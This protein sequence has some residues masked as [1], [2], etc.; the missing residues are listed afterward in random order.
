MAAYV[1]LGAETGLP[2]DVAE[3]RRSGIR[4]HQGAEIAVERI[5]PRSR[6]SSSPLL[7]LR[8]SPRVC[9]SEAGISVFNDLS[10]TEA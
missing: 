1:R 10:R 8:C 3:G 7:F 9:G 2:A 6:F 4:R 5:R